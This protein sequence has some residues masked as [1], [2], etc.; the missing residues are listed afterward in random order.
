MRHLFSLVTVAATLAAASVSAA[1]IYAGNVPLDTSVVIMGEAHDNALHHNNQGGWIERMR[2]AAVVFEMLPSDLGA[3]ATEQAGA[4]ADQ[5]AEVLRWEARGW[6]DFALYAPV[7]DAAAG[8]LIV[9][10]EAPQEMVAAAANVGAW[11]AYGA[12]DPF[13]LSAK[14][15]PAQL[16]ARIDLQKDAHCGKLPEEMLPGMVEAQRLRDAWLAQ[17]VLDAMKATGGPVAVITGNGHARSD[18]GVP[19]LIEAAR[20]E[21]TVTTIGQLS[22]PDSSAPYD[23]VVVTAPAARDSDPCETLR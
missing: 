17:A 5:L 20:P 15:A 10:G 4:P 22:E 9:G 14:L 6:G 11:A 13:D 2:P 19:A 16:D 3:I 21:L 1:E 8:A 18:W 7:F 12:E 23:Y